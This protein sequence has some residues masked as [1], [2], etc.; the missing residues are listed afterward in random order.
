MNTASDA[1]N[2]PIGYWATKDSQLGE[3]GWKITSTDFK[4]CTVV[5]GGKITEET[6]VAQ[7]DGNRVKYTFKGKDEEY[8]ATYHSDD[9]TLTEDQLL[10]L[11][12]MRADDSKINEL[13]H[14]GCHL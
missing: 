8:T 1:V 12:Y 6:G 5:L 7:I 13:N 4:K 2:S 3:V 14:Q 11:R 10:K 9:N